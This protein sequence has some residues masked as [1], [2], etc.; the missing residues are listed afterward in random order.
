MAKTCPHRPQTFEK[1]NNGQA[2]PQE[3][4]FFLHFFAL[5]ERIAGALGHAYKTFRAKIFEDLTA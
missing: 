2:F 3:N 4:I 1:V 5:N